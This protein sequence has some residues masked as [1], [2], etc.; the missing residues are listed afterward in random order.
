MQT[1]K[2]ISSFE[3]IDNNIKINKYYYNNDKLTKWVCTFKGKEFE[4]IY[5]SNGS[6]KKKTIIDNKKN[7]KITRTFS[8]TEN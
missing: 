1:S 4:E 6:V 3:Y 5:F 7:T 2:T 8:V